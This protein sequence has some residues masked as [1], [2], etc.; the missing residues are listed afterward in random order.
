MLSMQLC[1]LRNISY[2]IERDRKVINRIFQVLGMYHLYP[3]DF[4]Q[5]HET[6]EIPLLTFEG[7]TQ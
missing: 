6:N 7:Q 5:W 4:R 1:M 2:M 3:C